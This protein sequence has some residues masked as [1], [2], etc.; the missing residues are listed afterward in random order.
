MGVKVRQKIK[1][2][3]KPWWVVVHHEGKRTTKCVGTKKA[4]NAVKKE[5][6]VA[7]AAGKFDIYKKDVPTFRE[8]AKRWVDVTAPASNKPS[9]VDCYSNTLRLHILPTIGFKRVSLIAVKD[10]KELLLS[11]RN[12]GYSHRTVRHIRSVISNVLSDA[13]DD[14]TISSNPVASLSRKHFKNSE[15]KLKNNPLTSDELTK[16]LRTVQKH[17]SDHFP[18]FLLLART[19]MRIGEALALQW[20]DINFQERHITVRRSVRRGRVSTTKSGKERRVDMSPQLAAALQTLMRGVTLSPVSDRPQYLFKNRAGNPIHLDRWRE[21]VFKKAISKA[22]L[23]TIRIHDIRHSYATIRISRGDN[24]AD[25]SKQLG[26]HSVKLTLDVYYH[27]QPGGNKA[28]VD[29][30]DDPSLTLQNAP[31]AHPANRAS[32]FS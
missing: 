14:E 26:H 11:K 32:N 22:E 25:V 16:L 12:D 18:L 28:E 2:K 5:I 1:G 4:A 17:Y 19:G 27:W 31:Y 15:N 30:L 3:G 10:I 20:K 21:Q 6:E 8:Y 7:L 23:K 24:I 13:V 9:T 29:A